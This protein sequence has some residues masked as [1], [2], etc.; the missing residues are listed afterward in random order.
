MS[1]T[2]NLT[3]STIIQ[4]FIT[5]ANASVSIQTFDTGTIDYLDANA[6]NKNYPYVYLRPISSPGVVDK[7][8]TLTFE[9]Y[10]LDVP[11]LSDES[12]VKVLSTTEERIYE[13]LAWFNMG[14]ASRQQVYEIEIT[15]LSPVNEAFEDRVFGWVATIEVTTPWVWDYCDYPQITP[16]ATAT[17]TAT[18]IQPTAT[19]TPIPPSPTPSSTP[20]STPTGTPLPPPPPSPTPSPTAAPSFFGFKID[21]TNIDGPISNACD[22]TTEPSTDVYVAWEDE[23]WPDRII[24]KKLYTNSA[25]TNAYTA[26]AIF[27]GTT[28]RTVLSGSAGYGAIELEWKQG[29]A[30]NIVNTAITCSYPIL[31]TNPSTVS[32]SGDG[33]YAFNGQVN[34]YGGRNLDN[35]RFYYGTDPDNLNLSVSA[36]Y[37]NAQSTFSSSFVSLEPNLEYYVKAAAQDVETD[38]VFRSSNTVSASFE[39]GVEQFVIMTYVAAFQQ[40]AEEACIRAAGEYVAD[41]TAVVYAQRINT[42][43]AW[44]ANIVGQKVYRDAAL[45]EQLVLNLNTGRPWTVIR[46]E[47][48]NQPNYSVGVSENP[49]NRAQLGSVIEIC[50]V[51]PPFPTPTPTPTMLP[52]PTGW[53]AFNSETVTEGTQRD[54]V[55]VNCNNDKSEQVIYYIYND[56]PS[57][58]T[59]CNIKNST[60]TIYTS[61]DFGSPLTTESTQTDKILWIDGANDPINDDW[62][63]QYQISLIGGEWK[64]QQVYECNGSIVTC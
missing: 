39:P 61:P 7:V 11:K 50:N 54:Q 24:G 26:S 5:A 35:Y 53:Y 4:E 43:D 58:D 47:G 55:E 46:R 23:Q 6:V 37:V 62:S 29:T 60:G 18:P 64:I 59:F 41:T 15:D 3:Y 45:T 16:T 14:P 32:S 12:P 48:N 34:D 17:P 52:L 1:N 22:Y 2:T 25:L 44:P 38:F 28:Y 31:I 40:E 19:A 51:Q 56:N 63:H 30:N 42:V 8:R 9:L 27:D 57:G 21:D 13:L 49:A 20:T 36:S 10:S 33:L